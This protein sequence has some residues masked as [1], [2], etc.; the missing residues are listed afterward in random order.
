MEEF[1]KYI[2]G[3]NKTCFT[4]SYMDHQYKM[5][6]SGD[7]VIYVSRHPDDFLFDPKVDDILNS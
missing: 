2:V 3:E 4:M 1:K 6:R 5:V 7:E